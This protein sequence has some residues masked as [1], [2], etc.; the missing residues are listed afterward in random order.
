MDL[1]TGEKK[2]I[3]LALQNEHRTLKDMMHDLERR[4][5]GYGFL[6]VELQKKMREV[7]DLANKFGNDLY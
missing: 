4:G 7:S 1:T 3:L 6:N 5:L 2:M